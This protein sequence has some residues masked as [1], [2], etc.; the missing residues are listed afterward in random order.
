MEKLLKN[1]KSTE[2]FVGGWD[3]VL[4]AQNTLAGKGAGPVTFGHL[5]FTGTS[6]WIDCNKRKG[7]AI[8]TNAT[9]KYYY[10]REALNNLR[11]KIGE[12]VW[13]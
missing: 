12:A 13:I 11:Q 6:L 7:V 8:L 9:Q 4:D 10:H 2:R 5:G 1:A 3:R